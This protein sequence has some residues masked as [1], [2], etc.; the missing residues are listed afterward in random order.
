MTRALALGC[1]LGAGLVALYAAYR[2]YAEAEQVDADDVCAEHDWE[3]TTPAE[4]DL[5]QH[6]RDRGLL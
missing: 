2:A 5:T 1:L 6:L 3:A 4:H